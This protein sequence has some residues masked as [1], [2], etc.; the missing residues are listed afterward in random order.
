MNFFV[1]AKYY[2]YSIKCYL[3]SW[4]FFNFKSVKPNK[5][6]NLF[7]RRRKTILELIKYKFKFL[8]LSKFLSKS[9]FS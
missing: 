6:A 3:L 7:K 8:L 9:D 1:Y 5:L 2:Y 4:A